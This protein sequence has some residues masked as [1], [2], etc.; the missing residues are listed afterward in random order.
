MAV[1]YQDYYALLGVDRSADKDTIARAFKKLA[2]KYHPDLNPGDKQAEEKFKQINEAYEVLKD[3]KKRQMYDQLGPNWQQGQQ[4]SSSDFSDF[5]SRFGRGQG[6]DPGHVRFDFGGGQGGMNGGDFSDFFQTLFGGGPGGSRGGFDG[7]YGCGQGSGGRR[8]PRRG[9]DLQTELKLTLEQVEMG[10]RR[11]LTL[12]TGTGV[13]TLEVNV[14]KGIRDGARLR[15]SGQGQS[16]PGGSGDL[17]VTVR[18]IDHP[19]FRVEEGNLLC[20]VDIAPWEAVLGGTLKVPTLEGEVEI[21][22]PPGTSSGRKFRLRGRGLGP[23]GQRG[24]L[25]ARVIIKVPASS[26][27]AELRLWRQLASVSTFRARKEA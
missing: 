16:G 14:P 26:S 13:R 15:L 21:A 8:A 24:D 2:R 18:Y 10:G 23:D 17:Y 11:P 25:F 19:V 5:F 1:S 4:F 20:D 9:A 27:E 22:L 7:F 3:P 12:P 6:F